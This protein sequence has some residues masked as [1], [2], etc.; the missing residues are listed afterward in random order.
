VS[1]PRHVTLRLLGSFAIEAAADR[2]SAIAIRSQKGRALLAYLAMKPDCRARREELATLFWGDTTD[3]P[4]HHSLRQCLLSL[5]QDLRE[6]AEI[7]T[8]DRETIGL[9]RQFLLVDAR[10]FLSLARSANPADLARAAELWQEAFLPDVVLDIEEFASW[11]RQEADRLAAAAGKVFEA[12]CR[13]ADADGDGERALA[14]AERL[15]ALE[16]TREDRQR[17]ALQLV[18]R[19]HGRQAALSRAKLF[20]DRLRAELGVSP[21]APTRALI[22]A[23][24]RGDFEPAPGSD[25]EQPTARGAVEAVPA[26]DA[27][28][29]ALDSPTIASAS[30]SLPFWRRRPRAAA[31]GATAL[32]LLGAAAA[33]GIALGPRLQP[34]ALT[35]LP[36]DRAVV[37]LP[38][39]ADSPGQPAD[40]AFARLLTH[41]LISYLSRFGELRVV[42][43]Q[44][45]DAYGDGQTDVARLRAELGVQFA[46][47]G[48]VQ[49]RDDSLQI[50]LR[51]VDTA[52]RTNLWS[53]GLQR[54]RS[55]PTVVADEAARG[56]AR[57]LAFE[58]ASLGALPLRASPMPSL[59]VGELVARGELALIGRTVPGNL[60]DAMTAFAAV[61]QRDPHN[62]A[63]LLG[64]AR[65]RIIAAMNF[66]DLEL[67]ADL[68]ETEQLLKEALARSPNSISALY[69]LSLLEKFHGQYQAG[70]RTA[71]RCLE[72]NPS[73]LPA[74]GQI[75]NLLT[76]MGQPEQGLQQ[77]LRT[78][79]AATPNDPTMGFWYLFA[80]DA[81][82]ELGHDAAALDWALRANTVMPEAPLVHAWLASIYAT[83]GDRRNAAKQVEA[84]TKITPVR[85]RM[86]I[87]RTSNYNGR[88]RIRI[89]DGLRL[90]LGQT[91]S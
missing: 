85:T 15:L 12:L 13:H 56:I 71:Q 51:L 23:I 1:K 21:E 49:G 91:L 58:I 7:V 2:A 61:Q 6:A 30:A 34:P 37:V 44:G 81:E 42:S 40:A 43:E 64:I 69:S 38:F 24:R 11:R 55:D 78:I 90:A 46:V 47:V 73:F 62:E 88:R 52:T 22:E 75:G 3:G 27:A 68:D 48:R 45:S 72:L 9:R 74:Q 87:E 76:R 28:P 10:T 79:R 39:V 86:F 18:A 32:L 25:R 17:I 50:D 41:D 66:V 35:V 5:R 20:T 57:I 84:L 14:A 65:V 67:S 26:Q 54:A 77:V 36:R 59:T 19:R 16:P 83:L 29:P 60:S 63:A 33:A 53:D 80:A 89:F 4:A 70:I 82:L 8:A 31:W